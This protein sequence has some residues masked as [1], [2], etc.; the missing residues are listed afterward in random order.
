MPGAT[1]FFGG[2]ASA[3]LAVTFL[4]AASASVLASA[5]VRGRLG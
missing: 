4:N 3:T 1:F 2:G 5:S